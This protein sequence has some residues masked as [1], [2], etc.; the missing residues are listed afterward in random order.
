M[1]GSPPESP[2]VPSGQNYRLEGMME[3]VTA[4]LTSMALEKGLAETTREAYFHDLSDIALYAAQ[5][6]IENWDHLSRTLLTRY[7][8]ELHRLGIAATTVHR[9]L[10][11]LRGFFRYLQR[12]EKVTNDPTEAIL[13]PR[14]ERKL[15]AVLSVEEIERLMDAVDTSSPRGL[16]DRAM[17]ELAY[18]SGLRVSELVSVRLSHFLPRGEILKV[19]GKGSKTRL[20][21]VSGQ[22]R[23]AIREY[24]ASGRPFLIKPALKTKRGGK[25]ERRSPG[26][27][28]F[29]NG[30]DGGPIT[31]MGFWL[32]LR[33]Y[34]IKAGINT[35]LTPHTLRHSF[36]THLLE[37]GMNLREVQELLGHA[38][39]AT[40]T[41]YTHLD[42]SHLW[43]VI[44]TCHP[45]S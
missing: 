24:L 6:G 35:P 39:I 14:V 4:F 10:S 41:I 45:R 26:D 33:E 27:L 5:W 7:L 30:R 34:A 9:R 31:R 42:R 1:D 13:A 20:V 28:L 32:I 23:K 36:A 19:T 44:R 16:R 18:G 17:L 25:S 40:T 12:E 21:P 43:E 29:L 22:A 2:P 38:S 3:E 11:A 8:S 15:P 37:G